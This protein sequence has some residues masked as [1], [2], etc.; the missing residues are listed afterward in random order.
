MSKAPTWLDEFA[1]HWGKRI[2]KGNWESRKTARRAS[3]DPVQALALNRY[4][5]SGALPPELGKIPEP[6]PEAWAIVRSYY[7]NEETQTVITHIPR[8]AQPVVRSIAD[9]KQML[10]DYSNHDGSGATINQMARAHGLPRHIIK[11]YVSIHGWTHDHEPFTRQEIEQKTEQE[12][13]DNAYQLRRQAIHKRIEKE[14]WR[15]TQNDAMRWRQ[16]EQETIGA[17]ANVLRTCAVP[18]VRP[19]YPRSGDDKFCL[20]LG[21]TDLHY[22]K[23]ANLLDTW[24][25]YGRDACRTRLFDTTEGVLS[26]AC[27]LGTPEEI[28]VPI[29]SDWF[30]VDNYARATTRGTLQETDGTYTQ[31]LQGGCE[32]ARDFVHWLSSEVAPV[33][34]IWMAGNHDQAASH[35]LGLFL[36]AWFRDQPHVSVDRSRRPRAYHT[37]GRNLLGATHGDGVKMRDLAGHMASEAS[38]HWSACP[39]RYWITGHLH[40]RRGLDEHGVIAFGLPCLSASNRWAT[41]GGW[42]LAT[43][44]L[45]AIVLDPETGLRAILSE[46]YHDDG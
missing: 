14:K 23:C 30:D 32:L 46:S 44:A 5:R 7:V 42:N 1:E 41:E 29:G 45:D 38:E 31:I 28:V 24:N 18:H 13:A 4:C 22:G 3:L 2:V 35:A 40:H 25:S 17:L 43:K 36:G 26:S 39:N 33:R 11:K 21:P 8:V 20:V 37:Y 34:L 9:H 27:R 10:R 16:W 6:S 12:L 15:H 19:V